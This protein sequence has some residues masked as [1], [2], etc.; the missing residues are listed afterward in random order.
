MDIELE[1]VEVDGRIVPLNN[2]YCQEGEG[3]IMATVG[4]VLLAGVLA[5]FIIGK[6]GRIPE[7]RELMV[8]TEEPLELAVSASA[9][10]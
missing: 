1:H 8:K 2:T 6:S 9:V 3:A 7:C 4:G 5:G 10:A